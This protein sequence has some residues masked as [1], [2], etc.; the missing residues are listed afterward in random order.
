MQYLTCRELQLY[1]RV[2]LPSASSFVLEGS[3]FSL[4]RD[5][6]PR[7]DYSFRTNQLAQRE[8]WHFVW[9]HSQDK[10]SQSIIQKV[11]MFTVVCRR[12]EL[13]SEEQ[14]YLKGKDVFGS[15]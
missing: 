5:N 3:C 14:H 15:G 2:T 8:T 11:K 4:A 13:L 9:F 6:K 10:P 12:L 7:H 1:E